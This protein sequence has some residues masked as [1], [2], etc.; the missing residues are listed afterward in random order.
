MNA[1]LTDI[2]LNCTADTARWMW[3]YRMP[4]SCILE[5]CSIPGVDVFDNVIT[6][7]V[8][9]TRQTFYCWT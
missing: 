9:W 6:I 3:R 4:D 5:L 8:V 7:T 2:Q 1:M